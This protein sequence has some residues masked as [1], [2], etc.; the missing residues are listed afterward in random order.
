M[1]KDEILSNCPTPYPTNHAV[2]VVGYGNEKGVDYWIIKNSWGTEWA[3]KGFGKIRRGT[4]QCGIGRHCNV[5]QC[6]S[7][8]WNGQFADN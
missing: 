7:T 5:A 1:G 4:G 6:Q 8:T 3:D 2:L